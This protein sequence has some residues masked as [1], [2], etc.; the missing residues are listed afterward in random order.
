MARNA[1]GLRQPYQRGD[2]LKMVVNEL[3]GTVRPM[4]AAIRARPIVA[5]EPS[6]PMLLLR[7][8]LPTPAN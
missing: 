4:G 8:V 1:Q 6:E 5:A 2:T 7:G 3:R